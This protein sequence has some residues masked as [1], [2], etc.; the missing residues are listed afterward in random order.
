VIGQY[1]FFATSEEWVNKPETK[2]TPIQAE[3]ADLPEHG[4]WL[5]DH[6]NNGEQRELSQWLPYVFG[7]TQCLSCGAT[8][9]V[10]EA[11]IEEG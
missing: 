1:G 9:R 11:I 3:T 7:K 2:R 10:H 4:K 6:I 8:I 5:L